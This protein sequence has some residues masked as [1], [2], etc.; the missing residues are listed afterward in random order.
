[1][2]DHR[3]TQILDYWFDATARKGTLKFR[4]DLW[5]GVSESNDADIKV[6]F[7]RDVTR[8]TGGDYDPW[9]QTAEGR[10]AL[11]ILM[12][13]FPRN[14]Y[15]GLKNAFQYDDVALNYCLEGMV[16]RAAI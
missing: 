16:N 11:L 1:M 4:N 15:R 13:Q 7:E 6:H 10:L 8:A 14:I 2:I 3:A 9:L 12:D 5:F